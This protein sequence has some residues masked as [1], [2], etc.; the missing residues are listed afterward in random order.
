[1]NL[2]S[3]VTA[4]ILLYSLAI[5]GEGRLVPV[6]GASKTCTE[7]LQI[8]EFNWADWPDLDRRPPNLFGSKLAALMMPFMKEL[9]KGLSQEESLFYDGVFRFLR[10]REKVFQSLLQV[11]EE[12]VS[13]GHGVS[14]IEDLFRRFEQKHGFRVTKLDRVL[15]TPEFSKILENGFVFVDTSGDTTSLALDGTHPNLKWVHGRFSHRLQWHLVLRELGA[16]PQ[17]FGHPTDV[18]GLYKKLGS[19][20]L[21]DRLDWSKTGVVEGKSRTL[22][23]HL[24]DSHEN[25]GS[26]PGFYT[27][28]RRFWPQIPL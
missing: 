2:L 12:L 23:F 17:T 27:E 19:P 5:Y 24:F 11:E 14:A 4:L 7:F 3:S 1:M 28:Y 22:F 16:R 18:L 15:D 6:S 9:P 21:S 20:E 26:S 8:P 13:T 25:N 10:N